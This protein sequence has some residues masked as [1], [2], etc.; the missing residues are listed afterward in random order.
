MEDTSQLKTEKK[1]IDIVIAEDDEFLCRALYH[2]LRDANIGAI[3]VKNGDEV[4]P[5]LETFNPKL[6]LLDIIL[7]RVNGFEILKT[8][9]EDPQYKSFPVIV[10]SNLGQ[11]SDIRR[12][13]DYGVVE[14]FVK[15]KTSMDELVN[16]VREFLEK[17]KML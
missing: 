6:L 13:K 1:N 10:I 14:Y 3:C 12:G 15:A 9:T 7:P 4:L 2:K 17:N 16:K 11:E 8:I 5:A